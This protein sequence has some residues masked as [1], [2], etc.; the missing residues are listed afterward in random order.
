M[1]ASGLTDWLLCGLSDWL[2]DRRSDQ[3]LSVAVWQV[4][5]SSST[6]IITSLQ[7]KYSSSQQS[8]YCPV[9][10]SLPLWQ[11]H[12]YTFLW[13]SSSTFFFHLFFFLLHSLWFLLCYFLFSIHPF[14]LSTT[15]FHL[16]ACFCSLIAAM[17]VLSSR[18]LCLKYSAVLGWRWKLACIVCVMLTECQIDPG[19][20][21][22][23][24]KRI[25]L[26]CVCVRVCDDSRANWKV[27]GAAALF[28]Q[29]SC[30]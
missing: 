4:G 26:R 10:T 17:S 15:F 13:I 8:S 2:I 14:L 30:Q 6:F 24:S 19:L 28:K 5:T 9:P 29:V 7:H 27:A 22:Y 11:D 12:T 3:A 25:P 1:R 20:G 21:L 23:D 18:Q 16:S